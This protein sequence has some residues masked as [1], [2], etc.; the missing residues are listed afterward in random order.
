MCYCFVNKYNLQVSDLTHLALAYKALVCY[1]DE[2]DVKMCL[3]ISLKHGMNPNI[4]VEVILI[5]SI[6]L[7]VSICASMCL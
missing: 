1:K 5:F 4:Y 2:K 3:H 6:P 7:C